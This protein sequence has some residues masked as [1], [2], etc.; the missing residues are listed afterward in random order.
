MKTN[1]LVTAIGLLALGGASTNFLLP[2][3]GATPLDPAEVAQQSTARASDWR[4][5]LLTPQN[6]MLLLIDH[7]PQMLFGVFSHER[8]LLRNNVVGL[9]KS[10]K[11]F[12][13]P[14]VLTTVAA[15][16]FSGPLLPEIAQV[17]PGQK[18]YDRTSMNTWDDK[19]VV[20]E[21]AATGRKKL[22]IAGLWTEVC[23][24]MPALEALRAGYEVYVVTDASGGTSKEAHDE[25]IRRLTQAGAVPVTWQ[26]VLLEWQRDWAR[27]ETYEA[28][29]G[30]AKEH[31]GAYGVGIH[32]AYSMFGAKEGGAK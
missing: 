8:Q 29:T 18:I 11:V 16:S 26:Q 13:V 31:G 23:V 1:F 27:A 19:G 20:D 22:V 7:Q 32:Y 4:T 28:V 5:E 3:R 25:T 30:I 21:L 24:S 14:T 10:A 9:A 17:F 6:S 12:E 2:G 15:E